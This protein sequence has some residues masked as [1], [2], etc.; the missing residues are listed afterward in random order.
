MF[1]NCKSILQITLKPGLL[2]QTINSYSTKPS[3][4]TKVLKSS[5][6]LP[7]AEFLPRYLASSPHDSISSIQV[8]KRPIRKKKVY[9]DEETTPGVFNVVAFATSEEYDLE[10]LIEGLKKQDLY[11]PR[12]VPNENDVIHAVR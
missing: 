9:E 2:I 4:V 11:D 10:R 7:S 3:I 5:K 6:L 8:K 1:F 12:S